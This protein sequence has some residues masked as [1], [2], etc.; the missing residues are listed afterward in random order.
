LRWERKP[1][2]YVQMAPGQML[3]PRPRSLLSLQTVERAVSPNKGGR[4]VSPNKGGRAVSPNKGGRAVSP[5]KGSKKSQQPPME[6]MLSPVGKPH[7]GNRFNDTSQIDAMKVKPGLR[8]TKNDQSFNSIMTSAEGRQ[9]VSG[10]EK[11]GAFAAPRSVD[12]VNL[13]TELNEILQASEDVITQLEDEQYQLQDRIE[14]MTDTCKV[15]CIR[16]DDN[17]KELARW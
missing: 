14:T 4:A 12:N 16:L 11:F 2:C 15:S 7:Q 13:T 5:H 6:I 3:L 8:G 9:I 17:Q 1:G 10:K